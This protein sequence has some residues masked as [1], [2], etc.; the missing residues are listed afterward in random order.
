MGNSFGLDGIAPVTR[1]LPSFVVLLR[2]KSAFSVYV[3]W[4]S[5]YIWIVHEGGHRSISQHL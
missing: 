5:F 3:I 2:R 1:A 4:N